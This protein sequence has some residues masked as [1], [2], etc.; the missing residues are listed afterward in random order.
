M[1]HPM[2]KILESGFE[3]V[4]LAEQY[5]Q[6]MHELLKFARSDLAN[7]A[8][9][10]NRLASPQSILTSTLLLLLSRANVSP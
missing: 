1:S 10:G 8:A 5:V 6:I 2:S 3:S 4:V 9:G 7:W